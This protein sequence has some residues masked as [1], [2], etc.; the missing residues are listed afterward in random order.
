MRV[1]TAHLW[2]WK[3]LCKPGGIDVAIVQPLSF[4]DAG[5]ALALVSQYRQTDRAV[6]NQ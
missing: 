1:A 6:L 4:G 5:T 2:A 3:F